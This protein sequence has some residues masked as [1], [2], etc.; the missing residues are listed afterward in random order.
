MF[1][2]LLSLPCKSE[3]PASHG[4]GGLLQAPGCAIHWGWRGVG[5]LLSLDPSPERAGWVRILGTWVPPSGIRTAKP[6]FEI[7]DLLSHLTSPDL[8][9]S[10]P[11]PADNSRL[12]EPL[13]FV[14]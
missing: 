13:S 14:F 10:S 8:V 3:T 11:S 2:T 12:P 7:S 5:T 4:A 1:G 6:G 9:P